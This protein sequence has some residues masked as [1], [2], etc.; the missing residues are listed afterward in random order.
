MEN[1]IEDL[2]RDDFRKREI[3]P[4]A[5]SFERLNE[6]LEAKATNKRKKI[7]R[8][9]AYAASFIGL[10]FILQ[11][12]FKTNDNAT[13]EQVITN[14]K[15]KDSTEMSII[16][17]NTSIAVEQPQINETDELSSIKK[18]YKTIAI[19]E[20][21]ATNSQEKVQLKILEHKIIEK[22]L[23]VVETIYKESIILNDTS[24]ILPIPMATGTIG[25]IIKEITDEELDALLASANQL[26]SKKSRDSITINA[27]SMLY[28]IEVEINKPLPEKVLLTL[29]TGV[30]TIKELVRSNDKENN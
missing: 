5:N 8:V 15:I 3:Q 9:F 24:R 10:V 23:A 12:V 30:T 16:E 6:K 1:N 19:K 29:K 28:E 21:R 26:L 7:V 14:V 20:K 18:P 27:R 17:E 13:N 4:N 2:I 11:S 22:E 25:M